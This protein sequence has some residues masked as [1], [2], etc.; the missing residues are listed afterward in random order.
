MRKYFYLL[1]QDLQSEFTAKSI[2]GKPIIFYFENS[3]IQVP[4]KETLRIA[5]H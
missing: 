3:I 1:D 5:I 4:G 2:H